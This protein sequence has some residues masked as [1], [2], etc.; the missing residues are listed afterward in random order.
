MI[1]QGFYTKQNRV[2]VGN[3]TFYPPKERSIVP[4]SKPYTVAFGDTYYS[5]ASSLFGKDRQYL[6]TIIAELNPPTLPDDLVVGSTIQI[7]VIIVQDK[8]I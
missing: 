2:K 8:F 6:W 3:V 4:T 5:L 7:P 1:N